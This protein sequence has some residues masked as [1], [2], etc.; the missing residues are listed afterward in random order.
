M[1]APCEFMSKLGG[2]SVPTTIHED[3]DMMKLPLGVAA[4]ALT[5]AIGAPSLSADEWRG[6]SQGDTTYRYRYQTRHYDY[7]PQARHSWHHAPSYYPRPRW[8]D[9]GYDRRAIYNAG[10]NRGA[11]AQWRLSYRRWAYEYA[12]Y[13][14]WR[15]PTGIFALGAGFGQGGAGYGSGLGYGR[16]CDCD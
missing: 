8:H 11:E 4:I 9:E 13:R 5:L 2:G 3:L 12:A 7:Y 10:F 14:Q 15:G 16:R 1:R 6:G